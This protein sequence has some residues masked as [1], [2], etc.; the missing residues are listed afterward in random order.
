MLK[1][2]YEQSQ[3]DHTFFTKPSDLE[4]VTTFIVYVDDII[5]MDN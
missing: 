5:V 4:E 2:K 3:G 1:M